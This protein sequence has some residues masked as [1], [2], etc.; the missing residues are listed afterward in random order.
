MSLVYIGGTDIELKGP[1]LIVTPPVDKVALQKL[2][3]MH[4]GSVVIYFFIVL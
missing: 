2:V 1:V 4:A 3:E